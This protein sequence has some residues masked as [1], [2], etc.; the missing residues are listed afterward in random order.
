MQPSFNT[1]V[2]RNE[3]DTNLINKLAAKTKQETETKNLFVESS[4]KKKKTLLEQEEEQYW[5]GPEAKC[6]VQT[7]LQVTSKMRIKVRLDDVPP[8][9]D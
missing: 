1:V 8:P 6:E 9:H 2:S 4:K 3:I 5:T 7:H